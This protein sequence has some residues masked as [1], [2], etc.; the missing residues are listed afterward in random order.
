MVRLPSGG[1]HLGCGSDPG[2]VDPIGD[3]ARVRRPAGDNFGPPVDPPDHLDPPRFAG[4][5]REGGAR[6][7]ARAGAKGAEKIFWGNEVRG[8]FVG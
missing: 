6:S 1:G 8:E 7:R 2:L 3:M 4:S 5:A